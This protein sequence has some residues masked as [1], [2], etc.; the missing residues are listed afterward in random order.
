MALAILGNSIEKEERG[1][2]EKQKEHSSEVLDLLN[3]HRIQNQKLCDLHLNV[4]GRLFPVHRSVL[5]ACSPYFF[6]MFNGELR[7]SKQSVVELKDVD[8]DVIESIIEFAYT[9]LLQITTENVERILEH[10][11]LLQFPEVCDICCSFLKGQLSPMNCIGIRH[12]VSLHACKEFLKVV[13]NFIKRNFCKVVTS[14]EFMSIPYDLFK[15]LLSCHDLNV[16]CEERVY[17]AMIKWLKFDI[18]YR[19]KYFCKL[20]EEVKLPLITVEFMMK[21]VD[22]DPLIRNCLKC[23]DLL[24][25]TKNYHILKQNEVE[26]RA[27]KTIPRYSTAGIM[28]VVGGKEAGESITSRSEA[29]R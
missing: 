7:E 9:G 4:K 28:I 27:I 22:T 6:A 3:G 13:D 12:F 1:M 11:T 21:Y 10:A 5:A 2:T 8:A 18:N 25:E 17:V 19:S 20:L 24:D 15:Y 23:L 14:E 16:D 26:S 29:F